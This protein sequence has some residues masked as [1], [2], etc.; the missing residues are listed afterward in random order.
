MAPANVPTYELEEAKTLVRS[1]LWKIGN[2]QIINDLRRL[3]LDKEDIPDVF[4]A[5]VA[6]DF[7]KSDPDQLVP[8]KMLDIYRPYY[9]RRR[10]YLKFFLSEEPDLVVVVS[11]H[12]DNSK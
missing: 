1:N 11:F 6:D 12:G 7:W 10:L 5:L 3:S 2:F 4:L 8:G 9:E